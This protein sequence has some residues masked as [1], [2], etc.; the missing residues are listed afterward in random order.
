M[1]GNFLP[2]MYP[3]DLN[4]LDRV[5]TTLTEILQQ[6]S[7]E[8]DDASEWHTIFLFEAVMIYLNDGIPRAL[9]RAC[10]DALKLTGC[11]GSL[12][13]ADRLENVPGGDRNVAVQ[14]LAKLGWE[15]I[16]WLPKPGL[17][18]HMGR[19]VPLLG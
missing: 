11:Q 17:A 3:M 6:S 15:V 5:K 7:E 8:N 2:V 19:A 1:R 18:R 16:E 10:S 4:D 12:V 14:E 13:F 9:L